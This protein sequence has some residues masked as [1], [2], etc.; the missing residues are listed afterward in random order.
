MVMAD[1]LENLS[2]LWLP[3]RTAEFLCVET[4]TLARWRAK[5]AGP[6]F[7]IVGSR[8]RYLPD[9]VIAWYKSRPSRAG[10]APY[11]LKRNARGQFRPVKKRPPSPPGSGMQG[12]TPV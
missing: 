2:T 3:K 12:S 10:M 9:D 8:I 7:R 6:P 11:K 1:A 5:G 4:D